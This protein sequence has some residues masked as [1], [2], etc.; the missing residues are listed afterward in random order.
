M[1]TQRTPSFHYRLGLNQPVGSPTVRRL[2]EMAAAI[3]RD[4]GGALRLDVF[5]E[6]RL[7]PDPQMLA[8]MREGAL[9]FFV[10]GATL[11]DLAPSS[12]LPLLPFAFT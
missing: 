6:S 7:G 5:P 11:G 12:A 10:A 1:Q 2:T 4:T 8:D 3:E 9:E